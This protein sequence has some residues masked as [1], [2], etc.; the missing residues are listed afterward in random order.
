MIFYSCN[1]QEQLKML[2]TPFEAG[3]G[4]QT[5]TYEEVITWWKQLESASAYVK[6][7]EVSETDAQQPL[8]LV[9]VSKAA[10]FNISHLK[11]RDL[12][13]LLINNGIH[14]GEPDGIDASMALIRDLLINEAQEPLLDSLIIAIIPVYNVGGAMNR[15]CCSRANQNG[16]EHYGFRG[17]ARNLD[18]NRDFIKADSKNAKGFIELANALDP[19][20]YLETHVSNGADY[21]YTM[22]YLFSH[23]QKQSG[24][25]GAFIKSNL[26]EPMLTLM[27]N[28]GDK[29]IPYVNVFG[30]SPESGYEA[31][32]DSPRYSTGFFTL[33]QTVSLLT[34]THMLK[35]YE[36]RVA[37]T[38]LFMNHLLH[39]IAASSSA[40][41]KQ[42]Q[43]AKQSVI[44]QNEFIIDHTVNYEA[45]ADLH[46]NGYQAY[47]DSSEV[48]GSL[49]L[50]YDR[51]Q[52]WSKVIPYY[53]KL[54]PKTVVKAPM[55]YLVPAAWHE[56]V[57]RLKWN[58]VEMTKIERDSNFNVEMYSIK[59]FET[60]EKPYEG[61]YVHSNTKVESLTAEVKV[62]AGTY[63]IISCQQP[64]KRFI[65]EVLEPEAP[66]SYFNWNFYDEILQQKEWFSS[67]VFEPEAAKM[68]ED[69]S[70]KSAFE[71]FLESN[72]TSEISAFERL[73]FLYKRSPHFEKDK[74]MI[75]P[76]YRV[77]ASN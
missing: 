11:D 38:K 23:H 63:Y 64:Q 1:N 34:E 67:Y 36:N 43:S 68:L 4:N 56:V 48:T 40:L 26:E 22:T 19:D 62:L 60:S 45:P 54:I 77:H 51:N 13:L 44:E 76:V 53:D 75:Y 57:D 66:D 14:P 46:F 55:H 49:Q 24:D 29:M 52:T 10:N 25:L 31:F 41:L 9:L 16:P 8:H 17:N 72:K 59:S 18:L 33:R 12:P 6:V 42:R 2:V 21:P 58:G 39:C 61:H 50:K 15:N 32:Y 5:S 70:H 69:P 35:P 73:Y 28:D 20:I 71:S 7:L 74:F 65:I 37:S 47:F 27:E 30:K 3:N